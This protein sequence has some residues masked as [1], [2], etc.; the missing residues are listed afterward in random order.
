LNKMLGDAREL[1]T[2]ALPPQ[3]PRQRPREQ[4]HTAP[5]CACQRTLRRQRPKRQRL[6]RKLNSQMPCS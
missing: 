1:A 4:Q 6:R 5:A 2:K 3:C